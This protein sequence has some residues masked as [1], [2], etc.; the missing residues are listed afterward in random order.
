MNSGTGEF[1]LEVGCEEIPARFVTDLSRELTM[2]LVEFL[3]KNRIALGDSGIRAF[4]TPRRLVNVIPQLAKRQSALEESVTGPPKSVAFDS[5]GRAT[6]AALSFAH[7]TGVEVEELSVITTSKGDYVV[8]KKVQNGISTEKIL[9]SG[10]ATMILS[11]PLPKAMYWSTPDGPRFLRP[12]R[13]LCCVFDGKP[14]RFQ[15]GEARSSN[16]TY[17]H[18]ILQPRRIAVHTFSEYEDHL[19]KARVLLDPEKRRERIQNGV[20]QLVSNTDAKILQDSGLLSTHMNLSEYPTPLMGEFDP[21]FLKLPAEIL[22]AVMRDHQKYFCVLRRNAGE[23]EKVLLPKFVAVIDNESDPHGYVRRSHER[24]L[25]ARFADAEFFWESDLKVKL[26]DRGAMLEKVVFQEKLGSYAEKSRRIGVLAEWIVQEGGLAVDREALIR[27]AHLC[28]CDLTS[29]MVKEFPE[30]QGIVGGLYAKEQG[31]PLEV[32]RAIYEH[33]QP[34][35]LESAVPD[36]LTGAVISIADRIDTIVGSF[37]LGHRPTGS[38]DPFGLRRLAY[39]VIKVILEDLISIDLKKLVLRSADL[40][41]QTR[42][43]SEDEVLKALLEFFRD[44]AQYVFLQSALCGGGEKIE[45]DEAA[46]V[47][48]TEHWDLCGLA[49]R[50]RALHETRKREN[51]D[52]LAVSFKRIKNILRKSGVEFE[53]V[54]LEIQPE[55]FEHDEERELSNQIQEL[56]RGLLDLQGMKDYSKTLE[57]IA[58]MRPTVDRFFDKVLVNAEDPS[59]R[60]NRFNLLLSLYREFIQIADFSELQPATGTH[61]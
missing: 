37:T 29:Q 59:V 30:L 11:V 49:A 31:E 57:S 48:A 3:E 2:K 54:G 19:Y 26:E 52:S 50:A 38:R 25:R 33:Y 18:R 21:N 44:H 61:L 10:L 22:E 51:F 47:L 20:E 12:I 14:I 1:L 5:Q 7:K 17:G 32:S 9:E 41:R 4:H 36:C 46:A 27:S 53:G 55:L 35:N 58:S 45:R 39:G 34:E 42:E 6:Q 60:K 15:I 56:K 8:A 43:F 23:G 16:N 40:H 28:K 13:W 24:V